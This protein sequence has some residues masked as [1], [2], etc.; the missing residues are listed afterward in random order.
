MI[1]N[2]NLQEDFMLAFCILQFT[3]SYK[4]FPLF[5]LISPVTTQELNI[6]LNNYILQ[7]SL[8]FVLTGYPLLRYVVE[9]DSCSS[10][11]ECATPSAGK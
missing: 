8:S 3:G 4:E 9:S 2:F 11:W 1:R 5:F 10:D 6:T 7:P